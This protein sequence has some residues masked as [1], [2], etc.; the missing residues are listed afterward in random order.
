MTPIAIAVDALRTTP[1][2]ARA[3]ALTFIVDVSPLPWLW[4]VLVLGHASEAIGS[5]VPL[6]TL[7]AVVGC[8]RFGRRRAPS[9]E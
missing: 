8:E 7:A 4:H 1:P 5:L 2:A 9:A 6:A 3:V